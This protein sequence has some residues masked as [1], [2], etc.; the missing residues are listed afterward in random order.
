MFIMFID[1]PRRGVTLAVVAL[2]MAV[3]LRGAGQNAG[4]PD[5]ITTQ[6]GVYTAEQAA[7]G[8]RVYSTTCVACHTSDSYTN[9]A[10][11]AKWD[12]RPLSELFGL[13]SETM[14]EDIPASLTPKEYTDV[15]AYLLKINRMPDG[16][17]ELPADAEKLKAIRF[18][19]K[20][21]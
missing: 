21:K 2:V 11:L 4:T 20:A 10:F 19:A 6:T 9:P 17:R 13:I 5:G 3:G 12:G 7:A 18:Q 14:P 8:E 16:K 1:D 15:L